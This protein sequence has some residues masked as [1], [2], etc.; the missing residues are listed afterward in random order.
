MFVRD[1][2]DSETRFSCIAHTPRHHEVF[3]GSCL[4]A[5]SNAHSGVHNALSEIERHITARQRNTC[6]RLT[7]DKRTS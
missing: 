5:H 4:G 1:P 7:Q 2:L 6:M 3:R